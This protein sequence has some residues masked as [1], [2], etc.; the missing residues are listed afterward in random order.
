MAPARAP[1]RPASCGTRSRRTA[2]RRARRR[3]RRAGRARTTRDRARAR[4]P[5]PSR[6]PRRAARTSRLLGGVLFFVGALLVALLPALLPLGR[7]GG[8]LPVHVLAH[9]RTADARV[10]LEIA[11]HLDLAGEAQRSLH[12]SF[13]ADGEAL[14][15][16]R[17]IHRRGR[18]GLDPHL[19]AVAPAVD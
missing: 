14:G 16:R 4:S 19:T 1:A 13:Q 6:S 12:A 3:C 7:L 2:S 8:G 15:A 5:L 18:V 11:L 10:H 9:A 17:R